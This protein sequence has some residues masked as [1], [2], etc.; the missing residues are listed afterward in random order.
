[1][2]ALGAFG[3]RG[4]EAA[5]DGD[6]TLE[7]ESFEAAAMGGC[8]GVGSFGNPDFYGGGEAGAGVGEGELEIGVGVGPGGAI[9]GGGAGVIDKDERGG[10]DGGDAGEGGGGTRGG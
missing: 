6:T 8:G 1:V 9:A 5:V 4:V 7:Q 2:V 3:F 10:G